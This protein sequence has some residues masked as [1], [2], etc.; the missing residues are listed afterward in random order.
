M[1][2]LMLSWCFG[3]FTGWYG[4]RSGSKA[5][6]FAVSKGARYSK[7][8]V[9][10][11]KL[12]GTRGTGEPPLSASQLACPHL[13]SPAL[14]CDASWVV[15]QVTNL[16]Q[17][18]IQQAIALFS[19]SINA[20]LKLQD[21]PEDK[22]QQLFMTLVTSCI[23]AGNSDSV[24]QL[25]RDVRVHGLTFMS[26]LFASVV[27]LCTSRQL[28]A[29]SLAIY[30]VMIEDP[31]F[32][33]ADKTVWS[34]LTFAALETCSYQR[35]CYFFEKLKVCGTP[36]LKDYG[37]M[38][39]MASLL[40]DWKLS[41]KLIAEMSAASL[42]IDNI[43]YNTALST[44]VSANQLDAAL[45]ILKDM[46]LDR[47]IVDIITY[48]TL[49]KG[50]AKNG[51]IEECTELFESLK[52]RHLTPSQVTYGILLDALINDG[53]LDKAARLFEDMAREGCSMNTV[54]YTTVIKGFVRA[55][56]L[57]KAMS[58]YKKMDGQGVPADL[59]TFSILMKANCD[60]SKID[61]AMT[62]HESMLA[63]GLKPDEVV[64]N[65]LL[66]G[67]SRVGNAELGKRLYS[68]MVASGIRPSNATFSILLRLFHECKLL[69]DA[70]E[71]LK[72]EPAKLKVDLEPRLFL[73]LIQSCIRER[74]GRQAVETYSA[75]WEQ[76][77]PQV[78]AHTSI[79]NT[80]MK[81]NMYDTA[82]DI[83]RVAASK[84]GR[85]DIKDARA[86]LD[87]ATRKRKSQT[88][89]DIACS[90]EKLGLDLELESS[91]H[92]Q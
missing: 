6:K 56:D 80:C 10:R 29:D 44:C 78:S 43:T 45:K 91:L 27:K 19:A 18:H 25:L 14:L 63:S 4:T 67:C 46:E 75:F 22:C 28:F 51:R 76:C 55:G 15:P 90:I 39:R 33:V 60:S 40:G 65:N 74:C 82:A 62:L 12:L 87:G 8:L 3:Q 38:M 89:K 57:A 66:T 30:D 88:A 32:V 9:T 1:M 64:F 71:M 72:T 54:L 13:V 48:N 61:E 20:G 11:S 79:F 73:Q 49:M 86:L 68:N 92:L 52:A 36:S 37:N 35:G 70:V 24:M 5:S 53:Q 47:D 34:C 81:L 2:V 77:V 58:V 16:C 7:P 26:A 59:I 84:G 21:V 31:K 85:V 23:R 69:D 17:S 41:L 83:L 50:Y 42:E